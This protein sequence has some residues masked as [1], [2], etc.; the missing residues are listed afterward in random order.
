[1][2]GTLRTLTSQTAGQGLLQTPGNAVST[3]RVMDA[4]AI[5]QCVY[6]YSTQ[7]SA[8]QSSPGQLPQEPSR[9]TGSR[10]ASAPALFMCD[11]SQVGRQPAASAE[12]AGRTAAPDQ[13][14]TFSSPRDRSVT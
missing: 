2:G 8:S 14:V 6:T 13:L 9:N 12:L 1:M 5:G 4:Q 7:P 10:L 11:V 3:L